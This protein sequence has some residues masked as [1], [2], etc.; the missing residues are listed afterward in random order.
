MDIFYSRAMTRKL[1][2]IALAAVLF[3]SCTP[4]SDGD[5]SANDASSSSKPGAGTKAKPAKPKPT[6]TVAQEQAIKSA[7]S[8]L[9]M[10]GFSRAGLIEQLTSQAGEGFKR[11]DAVFA[12]NHVK[13][14]WNKE[15]VES[16]K[17]YL[18]MGGFSRASLIEQLSSDAGEKFTR[19]QAE[20]AADQ[21]G[22][23]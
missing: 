9:A 21:V 4:T 2:L 1:A 13:A 19:K 14:D 22:L 3:A 5:S 20:Y 15:A 11:K 7:K 18:Q 17:S 6:Y 12:V 23:K 8:Y 16:A 10:S